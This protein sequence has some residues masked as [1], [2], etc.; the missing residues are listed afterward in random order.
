MIM[1]AVITLMMVM[2]MKMVMCLENEA[3]WKNDPLNNYLMKIVLVIVAI[4]LL[5]YLFSNTTYLSSDNSLP[6]F[7][8]NDLITIAHG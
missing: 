1:I 3:L 5:E 8:Q 6:S 4:S 7:S 2:K